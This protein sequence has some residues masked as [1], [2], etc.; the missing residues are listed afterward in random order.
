MAPEVFRAPESDLSDDEK[1]QTAQD[2]GGLEGAF[3]RMLACGEPRDGRVLTQR[4]ASGAST[5]PSVRCGP[6]IR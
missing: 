3:W 5:S 6:P 1:K 4:C 2:V